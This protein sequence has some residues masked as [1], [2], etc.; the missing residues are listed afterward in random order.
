M[1]PLEVFTGSLGCT[2]IG[3]VLEGGKQG[4]D[5]IWFL[6]GEDLLEPQLGMN[7]SRTR[8]AL[9]ALL[10]DLR[11]SPGEPNQVGGAEVK[12]LDLEVDSG[13]ELAACVGLAAPVP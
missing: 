1:T 2:L 3:K 13:E 8:G 12:R 10:F 6:L 4:R 11:G 5:R 9:G 7:R